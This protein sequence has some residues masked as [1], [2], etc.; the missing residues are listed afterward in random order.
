MK[1]IQAVD[2]WRCTNNWLPEKI[3]RS[4]RVPVSTD[5]F[6]RIKVN[7]EGPVR[8]AVFGGPRGQ[9]MLKDVILARLRDRRFRTRHGNILVRNHS[10]REKS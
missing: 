3:K 4:M 5:L 7:I 1:P 8:L 9:R 6:L 2:G 10:R